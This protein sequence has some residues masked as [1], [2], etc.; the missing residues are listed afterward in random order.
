MNFSRLLLLTV[1]VPASLL[2]AGRTSAEEYLFQ[3]EH[4]L[5][6]SLE[7]RVHTSSA[8][9]AEQAENT[10]L[11]EIDRLAKI[12]SRHNPASEL[13][14]WQSSTRQQSISQDLLTV[15]TRA[16]KW[17]RLTGGAFDIRAGAFVELWKQ[18][19]QA[20]QLPAEEQRRQIAVTLTNSPWNIDASGSIQRN[21]T[22]AISLD[23]L[24]KG[25]ILDAVCRKI[26]ADCPHVTGL[27]INIGGDL[28]KLGS[29]SREFAIANPADTSENAAPLMSFSHVGEL[30][31][32]TSGGYQRYFEIAGRHYSHII[33]P[34]TGFPAE[35]IQSASVI[36]AT[37]MDADAAATAVSV[38]GTT[39]GLALIESLDGFECLLLT[40][41]GT[42]QASS[43]WPA[44]NADWQASLIA[45]EVK[46]NVSEKS[47]AGLNVDFTLNR[48]E[49]GRYRRPYV[50]V[51]LEDEDGFPV[52]TALL[53]M[54]TKQPGPRWHR[55][56]TRWYRNDR[57][58]KLAE[59]KELIGTI[60]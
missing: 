10:A 16:E 4:V 45:A 33:D 2:F 43:G 38:L 21:D 32:A 30:A 59:D 52:K 41:N 44:G 55:D 57:F 46:S 5:G 51:W 53:W 22:L 26:Q 19:A 36:A 31:L 60:S 13:M 3:H 50:A 54:Q 18:S 34:R 56:L 15:L 27:V 48:P 49:G 23:A 47:T 25:Y 35:Q 9:R 29:A 40:N 28:R 17:R 20:Q 14:Q 1:I 39:A 6:T 12:L 8:E 58:R 37:A 24:G 42:V 7:L 11:K